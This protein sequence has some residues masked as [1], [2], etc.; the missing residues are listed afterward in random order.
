MTREVSICQRHSS[1]LQINVGFHVCILFVTA[2]SRMALLNER[3]AL[4]R[5]TLPPC[6]MKLVY[7]LHSWASVLTLTLQYRTAAPP[8]PSRKKLHL[9]FG[10][11]ANQMSQISEFGVVRLMFTF[12]RMSVS[13]LA[14]TWRKVFSS[15]T[16]R[17]SKPGNS[18]IL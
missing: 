18:T 15:A 5:N 2:L 3:T 4:L 10:T 16:R 7:L 13:G 12:R 17:V 6:F 8:I 1:P 11:S 9:N 14:L